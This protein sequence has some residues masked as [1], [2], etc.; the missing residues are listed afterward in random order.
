MNEQPIKK[1][2]LTEIA[3]V[4][5]DFFW[6]SFD[7]LLRPRDHTLLSRGNGKGLWIYDEI[8]IDAAVYGDL[9][10]RKLALVAR[11][12]EVD[13]ASNAPLDEQAAEL[14]RRQ[15]KALK[16]DRLCL[17]LLDALLKG[18]A[19]GEVLWDYDGAEI[20]PRRVKMRDQRRFT[21]DI[22]EQLKLL[23]LEHPVYGEELPP[24]KFIVH[25]FGAKD[26]S[27]FG[28]GLGTR[29]FWPAFFKRNGITFWLTF[30]DKFGSPTAVAKYPPGTDPKDINILRDAVAAL[31]QETGLIIPEGMLIEF[32]EAGKS[33]TDTHEKL[34]RYMDEQIGKIILGESE[35][36]KSRA[37]S[38]AAGSQIRN[39]V[40]LELTQ[41]DSDLLSS[42]IND[43]LVK[44]IVEYNL[45]GA[46]PPTVWRKIA[47]PEDLKA[48]A[49]T[50]AT[51]YNMG[52]SPSLE[53]IQETYGEGWTA[54]PIAPPVAGIVGGNAGG[55]GSGSGDV[56]LA[57]AALPGDAQI[58]ADQITLKQ[59]AADL[60]LDFR[61]TLGRRLD[62]LKT[63]LDE[64]KDLTLFRTGLAELLAEDPPQKLTDSLTNAGFSA[65]L[66]GRTGN[67]ER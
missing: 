9:Q 4:T 32:L 16:Y 14:V 56:N 15:L 27:P 31:A 55:N 6:Q 28:L 11:P 18:F 62:D 38:L 52:F 33:G 24:R 64:T 13:A 50:D 41:A 10:K 12:W 48:K 19:V 58:R 47:P 21:F 54:R 20:Y 51:V 35:S 63:L 1:P 67:G 25:S 44:W 8:E 40:R 2:E 26:D 43:T 59:G 37:G 5:R 23:T 3:T 45:P 7:G 49:D 57:E 29:L 66:L 53:Y 65:N 39:E 60:A 34:C 61:D 17:G 36:M 22:D 46:N 42:T 30:A